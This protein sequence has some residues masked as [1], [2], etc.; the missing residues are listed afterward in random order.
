MGISESPKCA[1]CDC[2]DRIR[3]YLNGDR[4]ACD[5]MIK[6]LMPL[7]Q[8]IVRRI[9]RFDLAKDHEDVVQDIFLRVFGRLDLWRQ[10]CPFCNWVSIIAANRACSVLDNQKRRVTKPLPTKKNEEIEDPRPGLITAPR[11]RGSPPDL[12]NCPEKVLATVPPDSRRFLTSLIRKK[13]REKR[14]PESRANQ[15]EPSKT[16]WPKLW[17]ASAAA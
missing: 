12:G 10:E 13:S 5:G 4:N 9:L 14:L 11:R 3:M 6:E 16:G 8:T 17:I 7:I 15:F 1:N 2:K